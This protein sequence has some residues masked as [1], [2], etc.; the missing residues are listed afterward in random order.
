MKSVYQDVNELKEKLE[1][2]V[3][4]RRTREQQ[5]PLKIEK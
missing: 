1:S 2:T 5:K 4:E 3:K